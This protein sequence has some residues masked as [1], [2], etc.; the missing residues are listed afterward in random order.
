MVVLNEIFCNELII[1]RFETELEKDSVYILEFNLFYNETCTK[2]NVTELN[3]CLSKDKPKIDRQNVYNPKNKIRKKYIVSLLK[4]YNSDEFLYN[5]IKVNLDKI[6]VNNWNKIQLELKA[7]GGEKFITIGYIP[8]LNKAEVNT[9]VNNKDLAIFYNVKKNEVYQ[10]NKYRF[11]TY[12]YFDD[13]KL[14][15]K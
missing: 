14:Y 1:N 4:L 13:F 10:V 9:I 5:N 7:K 11:P 8:V 3:V 6:I 15:K 2:Y 12:Y